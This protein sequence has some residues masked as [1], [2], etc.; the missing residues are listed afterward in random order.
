MGSLHGILHNMA[1]EVDGEFVFSSMRD[2]IAG[3]RFLH[4]REIVHGDLK[5]MVRRFQAFSS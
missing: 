4:T 2:I 3:M 5:S 1:M